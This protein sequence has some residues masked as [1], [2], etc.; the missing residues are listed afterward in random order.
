MH[1]KLLS[2]YIRILQCTFPLQYYMYIPMHLW[3]DAFSIKNSQLCL[4]HV[5]VPG[6]GIEP[7]PQG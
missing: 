1:E 6:T 7:V 4:W 2:V 5:K 3:E